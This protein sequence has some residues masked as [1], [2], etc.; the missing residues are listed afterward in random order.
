M[1]RPRTAHQPASAS[2]PEAGPS[3]NITVDPT[4]PGQ[5]TDVSTPPVPGP[6]AE[7]QSFISKIMSDNPYFSAG[8]GLMGV[9][10]VLTV[11]R[12]SLTLGTTFAQR[13]M[14]VTLEIPS[15]DRSYPWFLEWMAAQSA[16]QAGKGKR[17]MGFRSHE[18]AVETSYKQH[19]N[20]SSEA[21]FNLVPGPGTHYFKYQGT[22]FQVKRERDAK[23]MDLH[24]GSPWETLTLT[25]LSAYRHLFSSLLTEARAL[26][27]A[28][29][30]GKTVVYTAWG[31]EWRPFGKPR[32]RREMGSVVLAEGVSEKIESDLRSFLGR[33]KWYAER[34]IP[35][36]R[37]YLLHGPPGSGKT[38]FI[39]AL[40]GSLHYNIC[41][42]NLAE[43]GLTDD[44]LNHLLG[45]VPERSFILL[46]DVD[47][48]FSRRV[49]TSEDGYK[50]SVTFSGLLNALDGVASS[51]E[52]IIFMTTNHYER[53][54]PALI[55]PGRVDIHELLDDAA[56]EQAKRLFIK[57]YG[58]STTV[59]PNG[60]EKGRILR[61]GE[62]PLTD[63]EVEDLGNEV[64]KIVEDESEKGRTISMASLQGLFIRTGAK[65]SL[66]GIRE[67]CKVQGQEGV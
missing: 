22:W 28:S 66:E 29:T 12:R 51:E 55:R 31:V 35:Y 34:G 62:T 38:S 8:A 67:L 41:L 26:A 17:P 44:K 19:E 27:E 23:L 30:E 18:L 59:N 24:S 11:L 58:N 54:D 61:E 46:E 49:Q 47:S 7:D 37:G 16:S 13:R 48:A 53:L 50:S 60:E 14:L 10:V 3:T 9:G 43:R 42:L 21:V 64:K 5:T 4:L 45:L 56:G 57:F 25:T 36:R 63:Q 40:A 6:S 2:Q 1:F 65:E 33:G 52:R 15:K 39:Q 20:G 32:S